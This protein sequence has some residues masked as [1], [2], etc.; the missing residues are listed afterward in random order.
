MTDPGLSK[1]PLMV[2]AGSNSS[3][4]SNERVVPVFADCHC[5]TNFFFLMEGSL[6]SKIVCKELF[7]FG[8]VCSSV[9]FV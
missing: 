5:W 3:F 9:H 8:E 2:S 1:A 4:E 6:D 7:V